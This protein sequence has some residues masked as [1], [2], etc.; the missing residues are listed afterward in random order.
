[1]D[2][3]ICEA[4]TVEILDLGESPPA[5]SLVASP[6][7]EQKSYPLVLE[8]CD[9]CGNVQLR[10]CLPADELYSDYLY[11]T[12]RSQMLSDHY[13]YLAK[14]LESA[15]YMTGDSNVMEI[16]SNAGYFLEHLKP[17]VASVVG[18][19]PAQQ[20]AKEANEAGIPTVADF[21][22]KES[23]TAA[24]S[25]YGTPDLVF[26][27]HCLAHNEWPQEMVE[28]A[29]A[30]L[31][32][33]GHFVVENAYVLNTVE[34]TEFDQI[35]H[36]HMFYYSIRSMTEMLKR[37]GLT[38]VDVTMS[39]I[40]GGSVVFIARK[41]GGTPS[42]AVQRYASREHLFL[43]SETFSRFAGRTNEIKGQLLQLIEELTAAGNSIQTYGAT[44]KGN[45]LLN[46]VGLT[47]EQIPYCVDSTAVK[48]GKF[49][50]RTG[51]EV[52]SE[53]QGLAEPPDYFL[54]TAWNYQDEIITK[55][56]ANGN[57]KSQ[58]IV[59]IPFVRII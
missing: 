42:D 36:E 16:G 24:A 48:Q 4:P 59:P 54:L 49:L 46:F 40:H 21:F 15:G 38:L 30:V 39:L 34:N 14:F 32:D 56:R 51:I 12:P 41:G 57:L 37:Y 31:P 50:P 35:Y 28:G 55:V 53:E 18:I 11:V 10:D 45:T 7:D 1:M 6:N 19:D 44:A 3:R 22:N 9:A 27:R 8:W 13:E 43:N 33:G 29:A 5:N 25:E 17:R 52:I 20:I 2:C 47:A 58:F 26:A 23:A